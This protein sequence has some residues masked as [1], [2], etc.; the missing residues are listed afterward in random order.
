VP[1]ALPPAAPAPPALA[2]ARLTLVLAQTALAAEHLAF[3]TRNDDHFRPWD[4]PRPR[5]LLTVDYWL[6]QLARS[7][8]EFEAGTAVRLAALRKA[9]PSLMVGRIN[10]TQIARGPFQSAM[11]GYAIDAAHEGQGLMREALHAV[12]GYAFGELKLHR[13]EANVR[14]ENLRSLRSLAALGFERTGLARRYLFID[15]AWRDHVQYQRINDAFDDGA[16]LPR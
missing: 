3:F 5:G 6:Q 13:L 12:I 16:L 11:L 15:G 10:L 1:S 8:A 9:A 14:P 7:Q 2:T 4:P